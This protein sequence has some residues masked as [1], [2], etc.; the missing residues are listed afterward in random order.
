[1]A[2]PRLYRFYTG[3]PH[4]LPMD[5][6]AV[7]CDIAASRASYPASELALAGDAAPGLL[8]HA[9]GATDDGYRVIDVWESEAAWV[10][11]CATSV[12]PTVT[13]YSSPP[14]VRGLH[15]RHI[16][17]GNPPAIAIHPERD[18]DD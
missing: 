3:R 7:I 5:P 2:L 11:H 4:G 1:M 9:A 13:A 16:V 14:V 8:L 6:Y 10:R 12:V 15:V 18:A 17:L